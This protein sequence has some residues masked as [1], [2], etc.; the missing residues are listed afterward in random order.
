LALRQPAKA[1][2]C[3]NERQRIAFRMV[4]EAYHAGLARVYFVTVCHVTSP[5]VTA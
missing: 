5:Q 3:G 2:T 1:L 4:T